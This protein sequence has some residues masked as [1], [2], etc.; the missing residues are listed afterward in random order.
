MK[1][2]KLIEFL[3]RC[4]GANIQILR[5]KGCDTDWGKFARKGTTILFTSIYGSISGSYALYTVFKSI[6]IAVPIGLLWGT[7]IFNLDQSIVT[8]MKKE[9]DNFFNQ[10][11]VAVP[12]LFMAGIISAVISVPLELRLFQNEINYQIA[13]ENAKD[14]KEEEQKLTERF[15]DIPKLEEEIKQFQSETAAKEKER[16]LRY[17]EFKGEAEGTD[18]THK[19]GK[20]P[21]YAEKKAEFDEIDREL[22]ALR[23]KNNQLIEENRDR[24]KKLQGEKAQELQ[25]ITSAQQNANSF[26]MEFNTL[27]KLSEANPAIGKASWLIRALFLMLEISPILVT[28]M[29]SSGSYDVILAR[30]QSQVIL[31]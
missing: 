2:N 5:K 24:I 25:K 20:G 4:S 28:M 30:K 9:K 11:V 31:K 15:S 29:S 12:R 1:Q 3:A 22:T 10:L 27:E 13:Q 23:D 26:L 17:E 21:V 8:N 6:E 7:T 14:T 18:G 16:K 19:Q